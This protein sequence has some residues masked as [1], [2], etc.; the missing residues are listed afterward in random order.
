M[1]LESNSLIDEAIPSGVNSTT[2]GN[3]TKTESLDS[4]SDVDLYQFQLNKGQG[5][6]LDVTTKS[7]SD[8]KASF[9]SFPRIFDANGNQLA[10]NNEVGFDSFLRIFDA[11]GNQLAFNDD[12][13]VASGFN[14]D[15]YAGFVAN[16][17]GKYYVGI[18]STENQNY[19]PI[20]GS[21]VDSTS[22]NFGGGNYDLT[23]SLVDVVADE[24]TDNTIAE[25]IET[26]IAPQANST[27]VVGT[28]K[29]KSDVDLYRFEL[30]EASAIKLNLSR[31]RDSNLDSY[32]RLFDAEGNELDA[33]DD[34]ITPENRTVDSAI[35][36][37]PEVAGEYFVGVSS[38]G[39]I[40]Y[41]PIDGDTNL[42][43]ST[44][45]GVTTGDY[46]L[47]LE[48]EPVVA[49]RDPDNT[50]N[51]AIA[52]QVASPALSSKLFDG[53]ID[54]ELDVDVYQ[55]AV[56]EGEGVNLNINTEDLNS[57]L[58]SYLRLFD[59]SGN[60]LSFDDNDDIN[61][62]SNFNVDAYLSFI[63]DTPGTYYAA[64]STSGNED[65]DPVNG[66]TNFDTNVADST[67]TTG[68]YQLEIAVE[69]IKADSDIDNTI[70]EAVN[71]GA[72]QKRKVSLE[73]EIASQNDIDIYQVQLNLGD[74]ITANLDTTDLDSNLDSYLRLFDTQGNELAFDNDSGGNL[75]NG[76][77]FDSLLTFVPQTSGTYFIGVS[78]DGNTDYDAVAGRNN[79][80][81]QA[82][83]FSQGDYVL[84]LD[85][86][87]MITDTD[88]DNTIAE[89]IAFNP[90][91]IGEAPITIANSIESLVDVDLYVVELNLGSTFSFDLDTASK[92]R[93][94][95]FLRL[96]DA[97][98]NEIEVN[99][100]GIAP[101]EE[102]SLDA[103]LEYT[104]PV[105][106]T[107]YLG[108]SSYGNFGY[109]PVNGN[110]NFS[111]NAGS[112]MG[113]YE[114]TIER[115]NLVN[116]I[117]GTP[118]AESL[119]GTSEIDSISGLAG[120][121]TIFGAA[122]GDNLIGGRDNDLLLGNQGDDILQGGAGTDTLIGGNGDDIIDGASGRDR[123]AGNGGADAFVIASNSN[124]TNIVD[125]ET[126]IDKIALIEG[127]SFEDLSFRSIA[128]GTR[129]IL[130][131]KVIG[132]IFDLKPS[133]ISEDD[134]I[135]EM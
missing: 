12:S 107:Y 108:V 70:A 15:S 74:G 113:D 117:E 99:D 27:A 11:N 130:D 26:V 18:S 92:S 49:D 101:K 14:L 40:D 4:L 3:V 21:N 109:D 29:T 83:G 71:S 127:I 65:Y 88:V 58:N 33:N 79:F 2:K 123:L 66:R 81:P 10:F 62:N 115:I 82:G 75:P 93:L 56:N 64:V 118:A 69:E 52:S 98:G 105:T 119:N 24:D 13:N 112:T 6:T 102:S 35:A 106:G 131:N 86:S 8:N 126:G 17:S 132:T 96:F 120:N 72:S 48:I 80:T 31:L 121:D 38:S 110:N 16:K 59:L 36:F 133:Q 85:I 25:A 45:T 32:L 44:N 100:D 42:N 129:I 5:I 116:G 28:V 67:R 84:N 125:F 30:P 46:R 78:S 9:N 73:G 19:D 97:E 124:I 53:E 37:A 90:D 63:P 95:T 104:T 50:L 135:A 51:E 91:L 1:L 43:F 76:S 54:S 22:G 77:D 128:A 41:D 7:N 134:F 55:F 68:N 20:N 23:F 94:D 89:A 103:Y 39:N 34:N 60:E 61:Q 47:E 87:R 122:S 57:E 114:L 111:Q